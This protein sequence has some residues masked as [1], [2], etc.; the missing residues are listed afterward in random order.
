MSNN[1]LKIRDD[2][3]FCNR[4]TEG[5]EVSWWREWLVKVIFGLWNQKKILCASMGFPPRPVSQKEIRLE[6]YRRID[7]LEQENLWGNT[8]SFPHKCKHNHNWIERRVNEC[9]K[10]EFGPKTSYGI[11]KV[12]CASPKKGLY[13]PNPELFEMR[14]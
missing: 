5:P 13:E 9:A 10:V 2:S 6:I 8:S 7:M 4:P 12:V 1:V 11:L 14:K 3:Q